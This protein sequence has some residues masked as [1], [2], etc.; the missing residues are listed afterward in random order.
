MKVGDSFFFKKNKNVESYCIKDT[1]YIRP[2]IFVNHQLLP[3]AC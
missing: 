2:I 3:A 1:P